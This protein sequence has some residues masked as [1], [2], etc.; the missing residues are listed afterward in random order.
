MATELEGKPLKFTALFDSRDAETSMDA[1][2]KKVQAINTKGV[3]NNANKAVNKASGQYKSILDDVTQSFGDFVKSNERFYS[4]IAQSEMGLQKIRNEQSYLNKELKQG[5]ITEQ[6]YINKTSQLTEIRERLSQQIKDNKTQLQQF[7]SVATAQP[8][9]SRQDTLKELGS[10]HGANI[11]ATPNLSATE[12][13]ARATQASVSKLNAELAELD[14]KLKTGSITNDQYAKSAGEINGKLKEVQLNQEYFKENVGKGLAPTEELSRQKSVLDAVSAEYKEMVSDASSAFQAISPEAQKLTNNLSTLREENRKLTSA[15]KELD[16]AFRNGDITQ[17]QY[18]DASRNLGVQQNSVSNRIS[19]T[20]K[21]L[22]QLD[23]AERRSIGSIAEKTARLTQLK[24]R[25]DQLSQSQRNNLNVGGKLRQEYQQLSAEVNKLNT[26]LN[27]TKSGGVASALTSI[28]GIA[29]AM[30]IAFGAQQLIAFGKELFNIAKQAEGVETAFAR[31]GDTTALERL[32]TATRGTVSD[33]ELMK[34]AVRS[35]NF[36]IPM[37]VLAKGLEFAQR[38]AKDTGKDV[39][40]LVNSFVDGLGRKSSLVLDNLGI[41]LVEIQKEV[42]KVGDYNIAVGNIIER[43]MQKAGYAVDGLTEKTARNAS[44]WENLKKS[45]SKGWAALFAPGALDN[46]VIAKSIENAK[47]SY[48]DFDKWDENRRNSVLSSESNK[49]RSANA[50]LKKYDTDSEEMRQKWAS[51]NARNGNVGYKRFLEIAKKPLIEEQNALSKIVSDLESRNKQ[52]NTNDRKSKGIFSINELEEDLQAAQ[53][54]LKET[55]DPKEIASYRKE[56]ET[57]Q[58]KIAKLNGSADKKSSKNSE[59]ELKRL[60]SDLKKDENDRIKLLDKWAKTDADYLAKTLNKDQ[61]EIES[62]R[63][64]YAEIRKEIENHNKETKGK[65]ISLIGLD[66]SESNAIEAVQNRQKNENLVKEYQKDYDNYIKYEILKKEAGE[67][68]ANE[69]LGAYKEVMSKLRAEYVAMSAKKQTPLGL[70][71]VDQIKYDGLDSLIKSDNE[72]TTADRNAKF[73]AAFQSAKSFN[74]QLLEIDKKYQE[75]FIALGASIT[76]E[77]KIVLKE[78]RKAEIDSLTATESEKRSLLLK[79]ATYWLAMTTS[80][81][82][83]QIKIIEDLL[84]NSNIDGELRNKLNS[85]LGKLE[86]TLSNG[87]KSTALASLKGEAILLNSELNFLI[88]NGTRTGQKFDELTEK[89]YENQAAQNSLKGGFKNLIKDLPTLFQAIQRLSSSLG[90]LGDAFS[91]L[92]DA[93]GNNTLSNVGSAL[94]GLATGLDN[95][96]IAFEA[97]TDENK[98]DKYAAAMQSLIGIIS[99][100]ANASAERKRAEEDY[101]RTIIALQRDYNLSI[102]DQIRLQA[103]LQESVYVKDY[104][105]RV[106]SGMLAAED[107]IKGYSSAISDLVKDGKISKGLKNAVDWGNVGKGA[108]SGAT[109]GATLGSVIPVLGTLVGGAIGAVVGAIAGLFGGKKKKPKY[110]DL[111]AN[112]PKEI[113]DVLDSSEPRDLT[114]V[115]N[116][117]ESLNNDKAVD[118]NTKGMIEGV[119]EWIAKIEEARAQIKEVVVELSGQIGGELRNSLVEA[120]KAGEDAAVAMGKTVNKVLEDVISNILFNEAFGKLF[121]DFEENFT[122]ALLIGDT[123]GVIDVFAGFLDK[124]GPAAEDFY[125]WM[126]TFKK[127]ANDKGLDIFGETTSNSSLKSESIARQLTES[128]GT[129][130][131]GMYRAGYDIMKQQLTIMQSQGQ[132]QLNILQVANNKLIA[133]NAIQQNTANTVTELRYAVVEL[134]AISKNTSQ[135]STRAYTGN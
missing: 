31:I 103:Q 91:N 115:K 88:K 41:S 89:L 34:L 82:K 60:A 24:Q 84:K 30:G 113:V 20:R 68:Y 104:V 69:Q 22:A 123:A 64:K 5:V 85:D 110:E 9:F 83:K 11:S 75:Q 47:K 49:L 114:E 79:G 95:I 71:L 135:Q 92:G 15:Q 27:G 97:T 72:R 40:Y 77:Q 119:L 23:A 96:S 59:S 18:I 112:L 99:M 44:A 132:T 45:I 105:G 57:I 131:V 37:D 118:A 16:A 129:E 78:R 35:D 87:V 134:K 13:F 101:Y 56:V 53:R 124:A 111:Y 21:E 51:F 46:N 43:E 70:N 128:T 76:E 121:K 102:N 19:E 63:T 42:K 81:I 10:A 66:N 7:N 3:S 126:E 6:E 29:G 74:D 133:L 73:A 62:V 52:V 32:R 1:F 55:F 90:E 122:D 38:R 98:I 2:L 116:L 106:Q 54:S 26:S 4:A 117:L 12:A 120:F 61:Q 67:N 100:V 58:E 80:E 36:K 94:S 65:A 39:D 48:K 125:S 33:L 107:A 17:R 108:A 14:N 86:K 50:E 28:R 130:I 93:F 127:M 25:Y 109:L 8:K